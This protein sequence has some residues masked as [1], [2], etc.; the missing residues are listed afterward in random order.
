MRFCLSRDFEL[1]MA[2]ITGAKIAEMAA[3]IE[4]KITVSVVTIYTSD[5]RTLH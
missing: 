3:T 4:V 2:V 5:I 1:I